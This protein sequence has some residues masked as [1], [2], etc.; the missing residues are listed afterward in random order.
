MSLGFEAQRIVDE[1]NAGGK[2]VVSEALSVEYFVKRF[3]ATAIQTEM[4]LT[5]WSEHWK[6]IDYSVVVGAQRVG[7][8]VTRAMGFPTQGAFTTGDARR[9]LKKKLYGLIV[10]RAGI[11]ESCKFGVAVLHTWCQSARIAKLL[12]EA[13]VELAAAEQERYVQ[14]GGAEGGAWPPVT[15]NVVCLLTVADTAPQVFT[16]ELAWFA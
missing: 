4:E 7:V 2:S 13:F 11:D 16:D 6:K 9:L 14:E 1:P 5:Y 8:S 10:A 12:Q 3:R 15:E